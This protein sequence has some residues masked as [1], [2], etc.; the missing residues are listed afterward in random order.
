MINGS[1]SKRVSSRPALGQDLT[2]DA[3]TLER[4]LQPHW[5]LLGGVALSFVAWSIPVAGLDRGYSHASDLT[6]PSVLILMLWY[7]GFA[8]FIYLGGQIGRMFVNRA[9]INRGGSTLLNERLFL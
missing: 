3:T 8:W 5:L 6:F 2:T 1:R 4:I 7:G 9:P